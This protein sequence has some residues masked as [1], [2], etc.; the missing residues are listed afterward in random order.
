MIDCV[1]MMRKP[2]HNTL[3][4]LETHMVHTDGCNTTARFV[5]VINECNNTL[6]RFLPNLS[7]SVPNSGDKNS[8]TAADVAEITDRILTACSCGDDDNDAAAADD[9]DNAVRWRVMDG[10]GVKA[11]IDVDNTM[12]KEVERSVPMVVR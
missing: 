11:V 8:S 10:N 2:E 3:M 5:S 12:K 4:I 6:G 7:S 9:D 1:V